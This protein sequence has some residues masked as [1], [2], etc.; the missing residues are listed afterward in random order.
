MNNCWVPW[1][2]CPQMWE[3]MNTDMNKCMVPTKDFMRNNI[4]SKMLLKNECPVLLV[5]PMC[6][7]KSLQCE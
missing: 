1:M 4:I 5:G 2:K 6:S 3:V 7:G